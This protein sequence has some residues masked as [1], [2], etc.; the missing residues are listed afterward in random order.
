MQTPEEQFLEFLRVLREGVPISVAMTVS[1]YSK[2]EVA[3]MR[4]NWDIDR[5]IRLAMSEKE[6]LVLAS[7]LRSAS[8]G[9]TD[10]ARW[11][12][13][14]RSDDWMTQEQRHKLSMA[15]SR[16]KL[17]QEIIKAEL[18]ADP[19]RIAAQN[20]KAIESADIVDEDEDV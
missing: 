17:E 8:E 12:L 14:R 19:N 11:Y 4:K 16:W 3:R 15:K 1:G 13:E 2:A 6:R 7:M 20:P 18:S 5:Q 9:N 10:A